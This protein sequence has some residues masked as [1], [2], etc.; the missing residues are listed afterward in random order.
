MGQLSD[1]REAARLAREG[2]KVKQDLTGGPPSSNRRRFAIGPAP[3]VKQAPRPDWIFSK[4]NSGQAVRGRG[5]S[6]ILGQQIR[7]RIDV[8]TSEQQVQA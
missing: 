4:R 5:F 8:E 3:P 2:R 6:P 1:F 7:K